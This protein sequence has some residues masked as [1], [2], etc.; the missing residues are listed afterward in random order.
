MNANIS[1]I[2][3]IIR[4]KRILNAP[5]NIH[6]NANAITNSQYAERNPKIKVVVEV[7]WKTKEFRPDTINAIRSTKIIKI[8]NK[9]NPVL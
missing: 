6:A 1:N 3:K 7:V 5:E 4:K 8:P 2:I 9:T